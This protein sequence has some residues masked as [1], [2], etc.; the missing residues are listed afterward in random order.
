MNNNL[1]IEEELGQLIE[2]GYIALDGYPLKCVHCDSKNLKEE[3]RDK[4]DYTVCETE[5]IC[6]DCGKSTGYWS[7]G[8]W[9]I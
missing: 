2:E 6:L 1:S 5:M 9:M 8:Y 4:I 7:Y 3:I